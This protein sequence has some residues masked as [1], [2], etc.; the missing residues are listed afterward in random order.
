MLILNTRRILILG[1][2]FLLPDFDSSTLCPQF[3]L[4]HYAHF[5]S[6]FF[7]NLV[8][9]CLLCWDVSYSCPFLFLPFTYTTPLKD[10]TL[11]F[12]PFRL[13]DKKNSENIQKQQ[14]LEPSTLQ[15]LFPILCI[16]L[17]QSLFQ[18]VSR[19]GSDHKRPQWKGRI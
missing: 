4:S 19:C 5:V 11:I 2:F 13:W 3:F 15:S 12:P 17:L 18:R 6:V 8:L 16:C 10:K 9:R 14:H 7:F 1:H